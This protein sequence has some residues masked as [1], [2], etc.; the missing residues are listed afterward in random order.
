MLISTYSVW[1]KFKSLEKTVIIL[2]FFLFVFMVWRDLEY[3]NL[4]V[5]LL[6]IN[7]SVSTIF[8]G[9]LGSPSDTNP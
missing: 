8:P 6:Q 7:H 2:S 3:P 5:L 4:F 9:F 1:N